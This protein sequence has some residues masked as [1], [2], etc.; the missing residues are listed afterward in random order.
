MA[1]SVKLSRRERQIMD[2]LYAR[3]ETSALEIQAELPE[4]NGANRVAETE[5][6]R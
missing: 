2:F 4:E 6:T 3:G 5:R 1:E